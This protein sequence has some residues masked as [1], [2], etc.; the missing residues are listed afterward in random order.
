MKKKTFEALVD[1]LRS[2]SQDTEHNG[3]WSF[4]KFLP[5]ALRVPTDDTYKI[6]FNDIEITIEYNQTD[7]D[8]VNAGRKTTTYAVKDRMASIYVEDKTDKE[9]PI[10]RRFHVYEIREDNN[11]VSRLHFSSYI[12]VS[13]GKRTKHILS[14][15]NQVLWINDSKIRNKSAWKIVCGGWSL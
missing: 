11:S 15:A 13:N 14:G 3:S 1:D 10:S 7:T 4:G 9:F 6:K 2:G 12:N 8:K 5:E